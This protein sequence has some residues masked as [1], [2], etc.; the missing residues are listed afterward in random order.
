MEDTVAGMTESSNEQ[1]LARAAQLY[2]LEGWSQEA[3]ARDF[4]VSRSKVSRMLSEARERRIVE[5][6]VRF[7]WARDLTLE[8]R[9]AERYSIHEARVLRADGIPYS[10]LVRG[11]GYIGAEY[12][13]SHLFEGMVLA[14]SRG[15]AM[16]AIA[17]ELKPQR[18]LAIQIVQMQGALGDHFESDLEL[19]HLLYSSFAADFRSLNAPLILASRY[20]CEVLRKEPTIRS[21]LSLIAKADLAIFGIGS[22][23]EEV[24]GLLRT[25]LITRDE[26]ANMRAAGIV[27][28]VA[29]RHFDLNGM[30]VDHIVNDRIVACHE[31]VIRAIP[32]RIG[33]GGGKTK[34]PAISA[35]L[36]GEFLNVLITDSGVASALLSGDG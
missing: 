8:A 33:V 29:G 28:D 35:A 14:F 27:G 26:L 11:I 6:I 18:D 19:S 30:V 9:L 16:Q 20:A 21:T 13:Q 23:D 24:S 7:P 15:A 36:R 17:S 31:D 34:V 5:V 2:F 4:A 10:E 12:L 1:R 25:G 3:I 22:T 32:Q